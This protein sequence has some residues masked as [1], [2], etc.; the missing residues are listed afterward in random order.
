MGCLHICQLLV[1]SVDIP[2][3]PN[4][5]ETTHLTPA[6]CPAPDARAKVTSAPI[7]PRTTE[8]LIHWSVSIWL[9]EL[10]GYN[11]LPAAAAEQHIAG[12][13]REDGSG[14]LGEL[15]GLTLPVQAW[16]C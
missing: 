15:V 3:L 6:T 9:E 12:C 5:P 16:L 7:T 11:P 8:P 2:V 1:L 14:L 13:Y 4:G 10:G